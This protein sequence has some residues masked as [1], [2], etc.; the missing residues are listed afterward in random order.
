M[1][2]VIVPSPGYRGGKFK[3]LKFD[4]S[5]YYDPRWDVIEGAALQPGHEFDT[6]GFDDAVAVGAISIHPKR[7]EKR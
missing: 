3:A 2:L 5:A 6:K 7:R 1:A 4:A